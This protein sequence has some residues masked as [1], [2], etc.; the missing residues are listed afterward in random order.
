[1]N[2]SRGEIPAAQ[3]RPEPD[4]LTILAVGRLHPVKDHS[5]LLRACRELKARG[6]GFSCVIAGEGPERPWLEHLIRNL[7]LEE[8]VKLAGHLS[9]EQ[10]DIYYDSC[11]VV[12]LTS[13]S[14]GIPLVLMEAMARGKTVLAP[15]I[16]GIPELVRDGET[17]FLYQ[18]GSLPDF[19]AKIETILVSG[20][21]VAELRRAARLHVLEHFDREKN[22]AALADLLVSRIAPKVRRNSRENPVLQ[23]I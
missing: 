18:A 19:I 6:I 2:S 16:T 22:L 4:R 11:D 17:G 10:L 15:A 9:R 13:R 20:S 3:P 7:G 8:S 12:V 1:V 21:A 5:F 14:E 23:Q